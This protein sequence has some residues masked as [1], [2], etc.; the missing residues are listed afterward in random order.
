[1]TLLEALNKFSIENL[2]TTE[3][4]YDSEEWAKGYFFDNL[5]ALIS[6]EDYELLE[7]RNFDDKLYEEINESDA[8]VFVDCPLYMIIAAAWL[9]SQQINYA[10]VD[11]DQMDSL[12]KDMHH[13]EICFAEPKY[14]FEFETDIDLT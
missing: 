11:E 7:T 5:K 3:L 2:D 9:A 10:E 1:M 8:E 14:K 6:K 13:Y 12:Y 4:I